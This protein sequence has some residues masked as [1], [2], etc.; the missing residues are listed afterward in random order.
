MHVVKFSNEH[1]LNLINSVF[2]EVIRYRCVWYVG[3]L[4][5]VLLEILSSGT[6][7]GYIVR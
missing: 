1:E 5:I 6:W 3:I 2:R 7:Y 4:R